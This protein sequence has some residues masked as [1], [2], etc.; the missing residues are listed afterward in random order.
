MVKSGDEALTTLSSGSNDEQVVEELTGFRRMAW[1][2]YRRAVSATGIHFD[3]EDFLI[4]TCTALWLARQEKPTAPV[5]RRALRILYQISDLLRT[6]QNQLRLREINDAAHREVADRVVKSAS[7]DIL[8]V[9][10]LD[11]PAPYQDP[12]YL[13]E[14]KEAMKYDEKLQLVNFLTALIE[15]WKNPHLAL[16]YV[17]NVAYGYSVPTILDF[18]KPRERVSANATRK[19]AWSILSACKEYA[20]HTLQSHYPTVVQHFTGTG[21]YC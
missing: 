17:L 16:A 19:R 18:L 9:E 14:Q 1:K 10:N 12:D 7:T 4:T 3:R 5:Y 13:A 6:Y 2:H 20:A 8:V 11:I 15:D 21:N